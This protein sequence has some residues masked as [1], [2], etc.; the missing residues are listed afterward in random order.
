M[1][2]ILKVLFSIFAVLVFLSAA[3]P[4]SAAKNK[5]GVQAPQE[6]GDI[7]Y[8]CYKKVNGQLRIVNGPDDCNPSELPVSWNSSDQAGGGDSSVTYVT[9]CENTPYCVCDNSSTAGMVL[10]GYAECPSGAVL[11]SAGTP[12]DD[13]DNGFQANCM[14]LNSTYVD[15]AYIS[16][17]CISL[18]IEANCNDL[19]DNDGDGAV[20]CDDADCTGDAACQPASVENCSDLVD[21]D[22]DGAVDCDD[23]DCTG[24]PAC[25]SASFSIPAENCSDGIDNDGDGK[26]DCKDKDCKKT[27]ACK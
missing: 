17:R 25:P 6:V 3:L 1:R 18:S 21:N 16:I 24:D 14:D 20:D 10:S 5:D 12:V 11:V 2:N 8:G 23:A 7:I 26:I 15:P 22:G 13:A 19:V 27:A 4:C 9:T